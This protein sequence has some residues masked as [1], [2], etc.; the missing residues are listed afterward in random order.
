MNEKIPDHLFRKNYYSND[1]YYFP[2]ISL[3][4]E[5]KIKKTVNYTGVSHHFLWDDRL[6]KDE[7]E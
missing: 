3:I 4:T 5:I 6:A 7:I 2:N 1:D